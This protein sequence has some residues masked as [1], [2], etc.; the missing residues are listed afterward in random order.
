MRGSTP[1][2]PV[3][4]AFPHHHQ[5]GKGRSSITYGTHNASTSSCES[6]TLVMPNMVEVYADNLDSTQAIE[7]SLLV[8]LEA[9]W[10]NLRKHPLRDG[11]KRTGLQEL[12]GR[13]K[14]YDAFHGKLVAYNKRY[15]PAHVPELLLNNSFRLRA[16]CW[17]MRNLF[18]LVEKDP[19]CHCP[20]HLL[21]KA[22]RYADQVGVRMNKDAFSRSAA[23]GAIG[24]VIGE[25]EALVQWCDDLAGGS[26]QP[27]TLD[28]AAPPSGVRMPHA[29]N[30]EVGQGDQA[31]CP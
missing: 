25:L 31:V 6:E 16:W 10:E 2:S 13:Q 24:A 26:G 9:R 11:E 21:E 3:L 23:P 20:V 18:L 1:G 17:R 15:S 8:D 19:R 14:A 12:Q 4:S 29:N 28:V 7:L 22:Y 27:A 5:V 30:E